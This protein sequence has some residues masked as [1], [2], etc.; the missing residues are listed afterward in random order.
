[1]TTQEMIEG[2]KTLKAKYRNST[3]PHIG[4]FRVLHREKIDPPEGTLT[5]KAG[6]AKSKTSGNAG[7]ASNTIKTL[8]PRQRSYGP[9]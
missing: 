5:F 7:K 4:N 9:W 3:R 2:G 6:I 8:K 1:M